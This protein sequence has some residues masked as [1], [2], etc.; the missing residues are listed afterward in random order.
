MNSAWITFIFIADILVKNTF[1][2][3][4]I[5]QYI[6]NTFQYIIFLMEEGAHVDKSI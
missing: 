2:Y 3:I 1:Q 5:F 6:E 4:Y